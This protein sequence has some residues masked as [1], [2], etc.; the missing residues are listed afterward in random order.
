MATLILCLVFAGCATTPLKQAM[1]FDD[2]V[3]AS[4]QS[5][6]RF[7]VVLTVEKDGSVFIA[8]RPTAKEELKAIISV[9]GLPEYPPSILIRAHPAAK[10]ADLH[11][12]MDELSKAGLW[13][14]NVVSLK[15]EDV[16][17]LAL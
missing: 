10:R 8:G 11:A 3:L 14:I 16:Q 9:K 12:V 7:P 6:P 1:S 13:T 2:A 15:E 5:D 17:N 4:L